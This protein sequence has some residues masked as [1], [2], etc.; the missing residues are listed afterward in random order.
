VPYDA[1]EAAV[2]QQDRG[3]VIVIEIG[4][5]RRQR[6]MGILMNNESNPYRLLSSQ[7]L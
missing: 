6:I 5:D 1:L 7:S 3:M 2:T 4:A